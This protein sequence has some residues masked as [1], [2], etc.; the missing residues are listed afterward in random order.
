[1]ATRL[2]DM[3]AVLAPGT[4]AASPVPARALLILTTLVAAGSVLLT[5]QISAGYVKDPELATLVRTMGA[6]KLA[7][8]FP[9]VFGAA[10]L[11]MTPDAGHL[12]RCLYIALTALSAVGIAMIMTLSHVGIGAF[13]FHAGFLG[14][15]LH[16]SRDAGFVERLKPAARFL[17]KR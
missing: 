12:R 17:M 8:I 16:V 5:A 4:Q 1:M 14:M 13:L 7:A 6:L 3:N 11:R 9:L 2:S 10:W 15:L